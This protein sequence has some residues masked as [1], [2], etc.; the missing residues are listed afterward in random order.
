[1][2]KLLTR[3]YDVKNGSIEIDGQDIRG[4]TLE[5]YVFF[6]TLYYYGG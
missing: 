4:V 3:F 5:R 6:T 2:I 1:M